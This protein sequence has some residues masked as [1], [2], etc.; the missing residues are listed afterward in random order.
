MGGYAIRDVTHVGMR[1]IDVAMAGRDAMQLEIANRFPDAEYRDIWVWFQ[2]SI[3]TDGAHN[4]MTSRRLERGNILS[5][6]TFSMISWYYTALE[7]TLFVSDVDLA[8]LAI[9]EANVA[10]HEYCMSLLKPG[11]SCAEVT[12]KIN[13]VFE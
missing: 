2:S 4:P 3:N 6:N 9:W 8:S 10:A 11:V 13:A 12:H 5:L 1:E 7:R